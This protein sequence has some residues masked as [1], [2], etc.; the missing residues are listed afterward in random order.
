MSPDHTR[1]LLWDRWVP[2]HRIESHPLLP[3]SESSGRATG[4]RVEAGVL[5]VWL[6]GGS[7]TAPPLQTT[8]DAFLNF[9][10]A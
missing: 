9:L 2:K 4:W 7:F 8:L 1:G 3:R 5:G 10:G 6:L